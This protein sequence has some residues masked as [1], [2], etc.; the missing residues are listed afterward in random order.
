V[1][2]ADDVV[3]LA[4]EDAAVVRSVRTAGRASEVRLTEDALVSDVTDADG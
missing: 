1:L 2:V 3:E 4:A